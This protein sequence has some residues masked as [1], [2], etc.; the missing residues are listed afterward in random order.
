MKLLRQSLKV[1]LPYPL[2]Q[3]NGHKETMIMIQVIIILVNILVNLVNGNGN[4]LP[5]Q[6]R[7]N[8][9]PQ[10]PMI[11]YLE[12]V[13]LSSLVTPME[14]FKKVIALKDFIGAKK[15]YLVVGK[16]SLIV[17]MIP[18]SPISF[19]KKDRLVLLQ[20]VLLPTLL[21]VVHS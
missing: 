11:W 15:H 21:I 9:A 14:T 16:V 12:N 3:L 8:L 18:M 20:E 7:K 10:V 5:Q 17:S 1:H 19:T 6:M 13:M 2:L 4:H